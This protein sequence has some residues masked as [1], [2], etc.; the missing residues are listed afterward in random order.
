M[1]PESLMSVLTPMDFSVGSESLTPMSGR[2]LSSSE[3]HDWNDNIAAVERT[4]AM[5]KRDVL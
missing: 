2:W 1:M 4:A 5:L 3:L